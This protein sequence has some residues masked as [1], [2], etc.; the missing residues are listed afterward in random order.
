MLHY[1]LFHT[2]IDEASLWNLSPELPIRYCIRAGLL[3]SSHVPVNARYRY[4]TYTV[5]DYRTGPILLLEYRYIDLL[6]H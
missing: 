4:L 2:C 6:I 3:S 5:Y 1:E